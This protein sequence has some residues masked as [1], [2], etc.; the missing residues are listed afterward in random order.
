[1]LGKEYK[2]AKKKK[3]KKKKKDGIFVSRF[4]HINCWF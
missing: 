2:Q 3:K 4:S 1:M